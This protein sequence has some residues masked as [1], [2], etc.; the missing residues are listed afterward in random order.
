MKPYLYILL[1]LTV[2]GAIGF[3]VGRET[4]V[5][6]P[7]P[8]TTAKTT[9]ADSES[10][11]RILERQ[12]EA[13]RLRDAFLLMRDCEKSFV[14]IDGNSGRSYDLAEALVYY[15]QLFKPEKGIR[16]QLDQPEV[17]ITHNSAVV[18]SRYL[19][20]SDRYADQGVES[21]AGDGLWLLTRYGAVWQ[22]TVF[23][24]TETVKR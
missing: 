20:T 8:E 13:Y 18:R 9:Q 7:L 23:F 1:V 24:R 14:E 16:L 3:F 17:S 6:P 21:V 2:G 19:K 10:I 15:H 22:V 4:V 12:V 11:H 5:P